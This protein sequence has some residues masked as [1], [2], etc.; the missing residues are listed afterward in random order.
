MIA[1]VV[2][3]VIAVISKCLIERKRPALAG[4]HTAHRVFDL[5]CAS[6][7]Q[8]GSV[9][10]GKPTTSSSKSHSLLPFKLCVNGAGELRQVA[11][12]IVV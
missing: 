1:T 8:G 7:A 12:T 9:R 4:P 3:V 2:A 6:G 11:D 5:W 10:G